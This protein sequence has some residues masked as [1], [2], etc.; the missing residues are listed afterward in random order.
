MSSR[1][2]TPMQVYLVPVGDARYRLY[3]EVHDEDVADGP[4]GRP[5][6]RGW[7]ARL[8]QRFQDTLREAE[9]E[10]LRTE[11]GEVIE[12]AGLWR[13]LMR[14]LTGAIA[15]AIA[16]QRLL[17]HVRNQTV[18]H[19]HHPADIDGAA[20]VNEAKADFSGERSKHF[21]WLVIDGLLVAITGP[22]FFFVPGPNFISWYFTFRTVGHYLSW[23]GA[24]QA[25]TVV[26]WR[27]EASS[28]LTDVRFAIALPPRDRRQRLDAIASALGLE[29]FS[30][31]VERVAS[32]A[33]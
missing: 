9:A 7:F 24:R 15:K 23:R 13:T 3:V 6:P 19:L 30:R 12:K 8:M 11:R 20:A 1:A 33:S 26:E 28:P 10:R 17:W 4:A 32:R 16:E 2:A 22:L 25:L 29:H 21:R 18:V 5:P 31:F 14:K 27:P